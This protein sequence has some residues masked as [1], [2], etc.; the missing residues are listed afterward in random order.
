MANKGWISSA[1]KHPGIFS[2]AAKKHDMSVHAYAE[3]H[4]HDKGK[5]G[6]R[7]RLALEFEAMRHKKG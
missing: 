3:A 4:K 1:V 7:A 6:K 5:L 2:A